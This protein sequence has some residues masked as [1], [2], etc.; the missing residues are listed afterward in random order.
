MGRKYIEKN[1]KREKYRGGYTAQSDSTLITK[2][3]DKKL[4]LYLENINAIINKSIST[5]CGL[6]LELL[7]V[8]LE[9]KDM[10][11]IEN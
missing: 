9:I 5:A 10:Q 2:K 6:R 3:T 8:W 1:K 4:Y 7:F 11:N